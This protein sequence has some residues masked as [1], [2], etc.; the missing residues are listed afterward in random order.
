M[1]ILIR[2]LIFLF[3]T[4]TLLISNAPQSWANANRVKL[5]NNTIVDAHPNAFKIGYF[6]LI[7]HIE[8]GTDNELEGP[9][10]EYIK[11]VLKEMNVKNYVLKGYP[12]QRAFKM[13]LEG[14]IDVLLFAA[15]TPNTIKDELVL[16]DMN[17]AYIQSGLVVNKQDDISEP[18]SLNQLLNK[19]LA[20]WSGGFIPEFLQNDSIELITI[21]GEDV[22]KRGFKLIQHGRADG[23]FHVDSMALEWWLMNTGAGD[24]LKLIK[25]PHKLHV[26]SVFSKRS[27]EKYKDRYEKALKKVQ[28]IIP[29]R[30]FFFEYKALHNPEE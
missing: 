22:Y 21:A 11:L 12:I 25:L 16:T 4:F 17:V 28:Q 9:A 2:P 7:P 18:L 23:F 30:K 15:K 24:G 5:A 19:R 14:E 26:K 1:L 10:V 29:Y 8:R 20:F 13:L 3:L 27:A 6:E